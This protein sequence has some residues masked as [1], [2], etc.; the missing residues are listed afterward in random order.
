MKN[1]I[2]FFAFML[3]ATTVC[4]EE[5]TDEN[6]EEKQ[7]SKFSLNINGELDLSLQNYSGTRFVSEKGVID[8]S[9]NRASVPG[10]CFSAGYKITPK[11]KVALGAEYVSGYGVQLDEFNLAHTIS[12]AFNVTG[13]FIML[14]IGH[15][16]TDYGYVDYFTNADPEGEYRLIS[17]P[18]T[19]MGLS[20]SGDLNCG[21]SYFASV[22]AGMN[23]H[24]FTHGYWTSLGRQAF[25]QDNIS[26][27][28]PAYTLRLG[29]YGLKNFQCGAGIYYSANTAAN[30]IKRLEYNEFCK[31]T[32][33]EKKK[34]PATVWYADAQYENDYVT[35]RGSYM[36]GNISNTR[37]LTAYVQKLLDLDEEVESELGSAA[38]GAISLMGEVGLNLKNCFY[39]NTNGPVLIPFVHYEY[40]DSQYKVD[41]GM[42]ADPR[43][44]VNTFSFGVN[45]K[46]IEEIAVKCN[47]T[48]RKIGGDGYNNANEVNF[49]VA[50][51][52]DIF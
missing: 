50:Y 31:E 20:L 10:I 48:T 22:S 46:P 2:L 38:K 30:M 11:W 6:N 51:D 25:N 23:A 45:W 28:S 5:I 52:F 29:Y 49:A 42:V 32:Y 33:G 47:Y 35:V 13:G 17:C 36:Q 14:P 19:E 39:K 15:C 16:N 41:E 9:S 34:S 43:G 1:F 37:C 21:L 40:Y 12:Q 18:W 4:A 3:I 44:Q 24:H 27:N 8:E 26:F 7:E